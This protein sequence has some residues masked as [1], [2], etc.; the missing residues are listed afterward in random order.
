[1][2]LANQLRRY[3]AELA[4][5]LAIVAISVPVFVY[6]IDHQRVRFPWEEVYVIKGEFSSAQ[7]VTPGQGQNVTV[8]GVSVG[9]ITD[10]RLK[11]GLAVIEMEIKPGELDAVHRDATML[12]RPKTGL[13][14]MSVELDPGSA[15]APK[16]AD[17]GTIP[18][19]QTL[20]NV[21]ADEV[22]A[23]LDSDT[24]AYLRVLIEAGGA[25][26]ED[27]GK[28]LRRIL[29]A[30]QP[31]LERT[32]RVTAAL[33]DRRAKLRR[34][35]GNL[36]LL[37]ETTAAHGTQLSELVGASNATFT[38]LAAEESSLRATFARLPGTL[39]E[40]EVALRE[41]GAFAAR[42]GPALDRLRPAARRAGPILE[43][44]R[45]LLREGEPIVR[46]Q[47]RP[48]V[49]AARP[50]V[51]DLPATLRDLEAVT[52]DLS[53]AFR[54]LNYVVNELGFNPP[55]S[56]EG[57]LFW[58]AWFTH[59]ANSIL[60]IEDSHGVAWR[61]QLITSCSSAQ[62]QPALNPLIALVAALP[63]CP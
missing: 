54:V 26:L 14:D 1:M 20:P 19:A 2:S 40:A 41:T 53:N 58:L 16:V 50:L 10:V 32:E 30:S 39:S 27:R 42:L 52:P 48:L 47:I 21:N 57:Y 36:R 18:V 33:A 28:D 46:T 51:A 24:R 62:A 38:A 13:N 6:I 61:G 37:S 55:G 22:L 7:A 29:K 17:G 11:D 59:N 9:E 15:S 8:A 45:P 4:A 35:V 3:W 44:I 5:V 49:R 25:G 12:L 43:Q 63:T 31:A 23:S 34:L 56:E 60:S